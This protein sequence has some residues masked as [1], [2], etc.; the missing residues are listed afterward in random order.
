MNIFLVAT[1]IYPECLGLF[2][3]KALRSLGHN[4]QVW[5]PRVSEQP[6]LE[7]NPN[8]T[9]VIKEFVD[10]RTLP[11][12]RF[13]I[14]P[15]QVMHENYSKYLDI[16]TPFYDH[17]FFCMVHKKE[18]MDRYGASILPFA[19][20][21]EIHYPMDLSK[22]IDVSFVG[23]NRNGRVELINYL[24]SCGV[25]ILIW[26]NNWP[27]DTQNYMGK[28]IYLD[29]KRVV[30]NSSKIVL[31]HHYLIGV[32]MRFFEALGMKCF[33]LS[34]KVDGI[35]ELGFKNGTHYVSYDNKEDLV[36]KINYYIEHQKEREKIANQGYDLVTK[37]HTYTI[38]VKELLAK[39]V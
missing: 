25:N 31:N 14:F 8:L 27:L 15:D 11:K 36:D 22:N 19:C 7:N 26:G 21:P 23:T 38:R 34:D 37:K 20:C 13:Y 17:V 3:F 4:I 29:K 28:A 9:I 1:T 24:V 32:N 30:Y 2:Y 39:V 10:P 35:E 5:D 16:I 18:V 12:P 33:L 6:K